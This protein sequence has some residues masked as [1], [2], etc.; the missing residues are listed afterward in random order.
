MSRLPW[1]G[2]RIDLSKTVVALA[3]AVV[4]AATVRAL[5][6]AAALT[7][8]ALFP[9]AVFMVVIAL[10]ETARLT[11]LTGRVTAPLSTAASF[12]LAL[13]PLVPGSQPPLRASVIVVASAIAMFAGATALLLIGRPPRWA[14]V[15]TRLLGV[16]V[17]ALLYRSVVFGD[18]T[19]L[20]WHVSWEDQRWAIALVMLLVG[21]AA[22]LAE[23]VLGGVVR[24]GRGHAPLLRTVVD[25]VGAAFGL[26]TALVTTGALV[27]LAEY[28]LELVALPLFLFP[29]ILTQFAVRR[30]ASIRETYRQTIRALSSLTER[31]GYTREGHASRV[32]ELSCSMARDL[33]MSQRDLTDVEYAAMLHDLGQVAL[34][35]PIPGGA[36]VMAAPAD[37]Q[38]IARD[39]AEIVRRTGVL[40]SVAA[41][42]ESQTTPYRQVREFGQDLPMAARIIKVANA[43]DDLCRGS[44]HDGGQNGDETDDRAMERIHLGLGYEYDP[45]VVDALTRAL[46]RRRKVTGAA[47]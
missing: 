35:D 17:A 16:A 25:E 6:D 32:S 2:R 45:R 47:G 20:H 21:S 44:G 39:G 37:Q 22:M 31:A 7:M 33:G 36:T 29:L 3:G 4:A 11:I 40:D 42:L 26:A 43:Y 18:R 46:E 27:A 30:Y 23:L 12:A 14:D 1:R 34:R 10:G 19:L 13:S 24:A 5:D 8:T 41:I 9:L 28:A 15:S 38:R